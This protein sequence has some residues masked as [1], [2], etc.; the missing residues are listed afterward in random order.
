MIQAGID[1]QELSLFDH[2][3]YRGAPISIPSPSD[4]PYMGFLRNREIAKAAQAID[5][6]D[7]PSMDEEVQESVLQIRSWF[8][9]CEQLNCDLVCFYY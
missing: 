3:M 9:R 7:L 6:A 8:D 2:L 4:F 1:G 5:S